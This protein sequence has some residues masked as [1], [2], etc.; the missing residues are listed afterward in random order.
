MRSSSSAS[1]SVSSGRRWKRRQFKRA[2][3]EHHGP[4]LDAGDPAHRDEDAPPGDLHQQAQHA[5]RLAAQPQ[6]HD[7]VANAPHRVAIG[8]QHQ[9]SGQ[10][11]AEHPRRCGAHATASEAATTVSRQVVRDACVQATAENLPSRGVRAQDRWYILRM[12]RIRRA[13]AAV[14]AAGTLVACSGTTTHPRA[15]PTTPRPSGEAGKPAATIVNDA[16]AALLAASSVRVTGTF[17]IN[18]RRRRQL[19]AAPRPTTDPRQGHA[20]GDG[21]GDDHDRLR[22]EPV[23]GDARDHP[24]GRPPVSPRRSRLLRAHRAESGCRRRAL[25]LAARLAGH[26]RGRV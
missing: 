11:G 13:A 18:D 8:I 25:A 24:P 26:V 3:S 16:R 20:R 4:G 23:D 12:R 9:H 6:G 10:P 14:V 5:R 17:S 1:T 19:H 7:H 15:V 2:G 22:Q 21:H